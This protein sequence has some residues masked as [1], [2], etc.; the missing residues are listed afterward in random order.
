ME[1]K[2]RT[3]PNEEHEDTEGL[4]EQEN[5]TTVPGHP[6]SGL[7]DPP[8]ACPGPWEPGQPPEPQMLLWSLGWTWR[9]RPCGGVWPQPRK[10]R[11][12][13][14]CPP[15][16]PSCPGFAWAGPSQR[17]ALIP[18]PGPSGLGGGGGPP[19]PGR[20]R[21]GWS[22]ALLPAWP[23]CPLLQSRHQAGQVLVLGWDGEA[24]QLQEMVVVVR[25]GRPAPW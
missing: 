13:T 19:P 24:E 11:R 14:G 2:P 4:S 23:G 16:S 17:K 15:T 22:A 12:R 6:C 21:C 8:G 25:G 9:L 20:S 5:R 7:W 18:P 1:Q 3:P 10:K